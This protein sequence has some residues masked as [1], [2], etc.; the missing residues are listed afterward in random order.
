MKILIVCAAIVSSGLFG[1]F[2]GR[3][4]S[5][6]HYRR[7]VKAMNGQ[8]DMLVEMQ[9]SDYE[10]YLMSMASQDARIRQLQEECVK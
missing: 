4:G 8:I 2:M 6:A 10:L 3:E 9:N 1:V 5:D 7:A